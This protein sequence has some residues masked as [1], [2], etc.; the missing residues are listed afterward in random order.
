MHLSS[1][2]ILRV[3]KVLSNS[4]FQKIYKKSINFLVGFILQSNNCLSVKLALIFLRENHTRTC[5]FCYF[6]WKSYFRLETDNP[7]IILSGNKWTIVCTL[8]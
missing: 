8:L 5:L 6:R 2:L 3:L 7:R 1:N 4:L